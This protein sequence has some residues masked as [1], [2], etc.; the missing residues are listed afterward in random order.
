VD[1]PAPREGAR[2]W[3]LIAAAVAIIVGFNLW[4]LYGGRSALSKPPK[5][6]EGT[7]VATL[8]AGERFAYAPGKLRVGGVVVCEA[9]GIQVGVEVPKPGKVNGEHAMSSDEEHGATIIVQ[10]DASGRVRARCS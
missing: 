7:V 5:F 4:V 6:P 2:T 9:S 1:A 8:T 10:A 3:L